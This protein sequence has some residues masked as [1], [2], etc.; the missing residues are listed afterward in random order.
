MGF[1][2]TF[3]NY[4]ESESLLYF[5]EL[6][7]KLYFYIFRAHTNILYHSSIHAMCITVNKV[8]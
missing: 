7:P 2:K 5:Y 8:I 1:K 4:Y 6:K 3:Y